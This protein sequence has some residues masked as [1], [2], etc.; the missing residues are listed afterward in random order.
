VTILGINRSTL[1]A[2]ADAGQE[3]IAWSG[4]C[5]GTTC[6][7]SVMRDMSASPR[8]AVAQ[9]ALTIDLVAPSADDGAVMFTLSGPSIVGVTPPVGVE[10]LESR[11]SASGSTTSNIVV[12]GNLIS[13]A[14]ATLTVRGADVDA[15][16]TV[17]INEVAGRASAGYKQRSDLSGYRI[18]VHK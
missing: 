3:F 17:K 15:A 6:Q 11:V 9:G 12:C 13:A 14:I 5:T 16:C 1:T 4:D 8:F 2:V 7:L 10:L 18:T